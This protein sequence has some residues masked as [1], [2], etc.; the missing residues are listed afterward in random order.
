MIYFFLAYIVFQVGYDQWGSQAV[1]DKI[2]YF[3][4]QYG[5]IAALSLYQ[6]LQGKYYIFYY[7]F[8]LIMLTI[9]ILEFR[10]W[11]MDV[12]TLTMMVSPPAI[13]LFSIVVVLLF[14]FLFISKRKRWT[15]LRTTGN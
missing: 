14:S 5:W 7:L 15:K 3:A 13:S 8:A 9:S 1:N 10:S 11:N 6:A 2:I 4:F 12:E